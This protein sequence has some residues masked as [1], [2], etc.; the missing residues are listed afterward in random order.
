MSVI[1]KK[2][3]EA[4]PPS[5]PMWAVSSTTPTSL[6]DDGIM[7]GIIQIFPAQDPMACDHHT[8]II[9]NDLDISNSLEYEA[10][11]KCG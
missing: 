5:G 9:Q 2:T 1:H 11:N 10:E 8:L 6:S 3:A 7:I 4:R